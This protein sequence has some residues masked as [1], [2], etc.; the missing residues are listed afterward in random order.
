[1]SHIR[2]LVILHGLPSS[3][4]STLAKKMFDETMQK[5]LTCV[6]ASTDS[7]FIENGNYVFDPK[8]LGYNHQRNKDRVQ[9]AVNVGID[10]IIVDNTNLTL[11][12]VYPYALMGIKANYSIFLQEPATTWARD[13][14]ELMKRGTHNVPRQSYERMLQRMQEIEDILPKLTSKLQEETG[15][16]LQSLYTHSIGMINE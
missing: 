2:Q 6:I 13:I 1:M 9:Q 11:D 10:V 15:K 7:F 12:E 4:K 5:S 8:K 16:K 3:G 14:D